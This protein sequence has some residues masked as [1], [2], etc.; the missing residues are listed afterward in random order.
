MME[1][2][3]VRRR[4]SAFSLIE[5]LVIVAVIMVL[6]AALY[7]ALLKAK[8]WG[9]AARCAS[10]LHQLQ[11]AALNRATD[12]NRLPASVSYWWQNID[13]DWWH[14][15][16]WVA[17]DTWPGYP[18]D[19][20]RPTKPTSGFNYSWRG[21]SGLAC[22]TNGSLWGYARQEKDIY[23]C[24][25][26]ALKSV[27][28][29]TDAVRSYSM[30]TALHWRVYFDVSSVAV[31]TVLFGDDNGLRSGQTDSQFATNEVGRWHVNRGQV[32]Y[33]DGHVDKL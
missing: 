32:V 24:P 5:L 25:T 30:N 28:G 2:V 8:E 21:A 20:P 23:L 3:G 17:W 1:R 19:G 27:C 31:R 7:P 26:F 10:N 6:A 11:L 29:Q 12:A 13:G 22:I 15:R 18:A 9:R 4:G 16:G 14:E 33:L